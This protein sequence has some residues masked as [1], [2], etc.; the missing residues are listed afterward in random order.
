M[1]TTTEKK[2]TLRVMVHYPAAAQ[3]FKDEDTDPNETVGELKSRVL[4]AFGLAEG[5]TS[6]GNQVSYTLYRHKTPLE[7][8]VQTLGELA[9]DKRVLQLKLAQQ[10]TQG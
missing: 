9:D 2:M 4:S 6:D 7:N 5:A 3:P 10:I 1:S 8:P